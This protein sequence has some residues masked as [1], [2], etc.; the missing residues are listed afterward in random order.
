V[1]SV[2]ETQVV[3]WC[4]GCAEAVEAS[5]L[6]PKYEC[7]SC[8]SE[9]SRSMSADGDSHRC[10]DCNKFGS[11]VSEEA[12]PNCGE[13]CQEQEM[14]LCAEHDQLYEIGGACPDCDV[15]P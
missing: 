12:C 11:K 13:D 6:E 8:G 14:G 3:W 1:T 4:E 7:G 2:P 9:Y 15:T 5:D 10:P